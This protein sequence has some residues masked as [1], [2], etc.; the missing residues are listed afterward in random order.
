LTAQFCREQFGFTHIEAHLD[1]VHYND[2]RGDRRSLAIPHQYSDFN[3]YT[4]DSLK[5]EDIWTGRELGKA[6]DGMIAL[7]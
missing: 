4:A 6:I 7:P 3:E 2:K 1:R 5:V